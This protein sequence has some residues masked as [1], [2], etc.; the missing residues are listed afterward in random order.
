[1]PV[2][3][4]QYWTISSIAQKR[5][6]YGKYV[7]KEY[8]PGMN[9]LGLHVV[10][11]WSVL[12]GAGGEIVFESVGND[13]DLIESALKEQRFKELNENLFNYIRDYSTKILIPTG[14]KDAYSKDIKKDTVKLNQ[15]WDIITAA[16]DEYERF[17]T[18]EYYP[19]LENLGIKVAGEWEILI[20]AGPHIL[21]EG[22]A[23]DVGSLIENLQ[24]QKYRDARRKLKGLVVNYQCRILSFHIHKVKGY[25]SVYYDMWD[26]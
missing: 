9:S 25:K 16:K 14:R 7:L 24:S 15:S 11:C 19:L 5:E 8:I 3:F 10:A 2:K 26:L 21:C 6:E 4:N 17:V 22:R 1:M 12:V 13:L 18:E 20:G 23:S